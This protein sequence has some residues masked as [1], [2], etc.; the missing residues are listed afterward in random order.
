VQIEEVRNTPVTTAIDAP[1]GLVKTDSRLFRA[2]VFAVFV[3]LMLAT[4]A[5]L[6]V[7]HRPWS[8]FLRK[9]AKAH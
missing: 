8:R 3:G 9:D 5:A 2:S 7:E 6:A 1:E 4:L